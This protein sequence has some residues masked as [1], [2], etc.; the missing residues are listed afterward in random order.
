MRLSETFTVPK[1][2]ALLY[3]FVNTLDVRRY[4]EHGTVHAGGDAIATPALLEIWMRQHGRLD[5][6]RT[7]T[8]TEH[9]D[10]LELRTALRAL[11]ELNPANRA[12]EA[13]VGEQ[14]THAAARFPLAMRMK[15]GKGPEL[16]P[17]G[18]TSV[19][20]LADV[21]G[22]LQRLENEGGLDR[23]KTCASDECGWIFFDRSKP[24]SRRW[25]SSARCGNREKTRSYR[26][27]TKLT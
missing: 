26:N 7:I 1:K 6:D 24:G 20:G 22:E 23:V 11:F 12:I 15:T 2:L 10:A 5:A 4:T 16:A 25:C 13:T 18:T 17:A 3:D 9:E 8:G 19:S 14:L 27:R 21:L